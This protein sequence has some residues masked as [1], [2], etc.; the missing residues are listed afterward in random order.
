MIF[1]LEGSQYF[2]YEWLQ[3]ISTE[4]TQDAHPKIIDVLM[5]LIFRIGQ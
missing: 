2:I 4:V 5:K 1:D 3:P